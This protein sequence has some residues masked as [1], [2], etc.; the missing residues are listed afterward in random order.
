MNISKKADMVSFFYRSEQ[1]YLG[2]YDIIIPWIG[3][4]DLSN[5]QKASE[6]DIN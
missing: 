2:I 5:H 1:R 3:K 6:P 4:V